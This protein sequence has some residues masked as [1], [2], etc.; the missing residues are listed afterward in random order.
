[1]VSIAMESLPSA[2]AFSPELATRLADAR[3][4][5]SSHVRHRAGDGGPRYTNR[6]A[7]ESSP[8][9]LA[10]AHNPVDWRPWGDDAFAEA[11]RLG[12]PVFLSIG[13]STCHWCH[14]MAEESFEDET[15]AAFLNGRYVSIKLDREERPDVDALYLHAAEQLTGS[16]GWPLSVWLTPEREPFFAGTYFPPRAGG[17]GAELG[18][19]EILTELDRLYREQPARIAQA[20]QALVEAVRADVEVPAGVERSGRGPGAKPSPLALISTA[21]EQCARAFD[22]QHGGLRVV[23]KF[24]SQVPIRLLLR[25]AHRTGDERAQ[26]MALQTLEAMAKGGIYDHLV[27]GFHRY[28]T[29]AEWEVPHFEKML[30]DNALLIPAYAEAWQVTQRDQFLRIVRQTCDEL[31]LTFAAPEGGFFSALDADSEGEE[32]RFYLW[33]EDEIRAVLGPGEQTET[34]LL[35][36]RVTP[37]GNFEGRNILRETVCDETIVHALAEARATLAR[38]RSQRVPP[39]CDQKIIAAWNGLATSAFVMAGWVTGDARYVD[40]AERAATFVLERMRD[41]RSGRLVRSFCGGRLGVLGFLS[42]HACVAAGLLDLFEHTGEPRWLEQALDLCEETERLFADPAHG[43]WFA[44]S[45]K[46]ERLLA[47][48]RPLVDGA[49]PSGASVALLNAARLAVLTDD[50]RWTDIA[51]RAL[52]FYSP[53]VERQPLAMAESLRAFDFLAGPVAQIVLALP[54]SN[55]EDPLEQAL[56]RTFCP[57]RV[58]VKGTPGSEA[59]HKLEASVPLLDGRVAESGLATAYVCS[60]GHCELP[61]TSPD[62]LV[63]QLVQNGGP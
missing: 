56:R 4:L 40:A 16:G 49:E 23:H 21:V 34:F 61:T 24:P 26:Q 14:V 45:T 57:R 48:E 38:V 25:H 37:D 1:M 58:L 51:R 41:P 6:L 32:G 2:P 36:Y 53:L 18:F 63:R 13:Y 5:A 27:G 47:R 54:S 10:H 42:D 31:L 59:W 11:R 29:D 20:A 15:I 19:L 12:R 44:T 28:A 39:S 22:E 7:L 35:H 9:L 62:E 3:S 8:Y 30:Y 43:G 46:H 52:E 50:G 60:N 55:G 33:T 17:R